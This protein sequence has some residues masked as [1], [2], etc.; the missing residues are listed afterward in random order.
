[1]V[2][3]VSSVLSKAPVHVDLRTSGSITASDKAKVDAAAEVVRTKGPDTII[4]ADGVSKTAIEA[5]QHWAFY[6][7]KQDRR[8]YAARVYQQLTGRP[9]VDTPGVVA[10]KNGPTANTNAS[11]GV[12]DTVGN[13]VTR[14][15]QGPSENIGTAA[16]AAAGEKVKS[17]IVLVGAL[18]AAALVVAVVLIKRR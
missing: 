11:G 1:M 14:V 15:T 18:L 17:T 6:M 8:D 3:F 2:P 7:A 12:L 13:W 4:V 16:G 10:A 5:I 9:P